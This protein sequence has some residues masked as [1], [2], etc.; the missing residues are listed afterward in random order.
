ME[1]AV[2]IE[3]PSQDVLHFPCRPSKKAFSGDCRQLDEWRNEVM[4]R[5]GADPRKGRSLTHASA[6]SYIQIARGFTRYVESRIS[7]NSDLSS[8]LAVEKGAWLE[9][10][11][12]QLAENAKGLNRRSST[13]QLFTKNRAILLGDFV[14]LMVERLLLSKSCLSVITRIPLRPSDP[15]KAVA[16]LPLLS[17][18]N[19]RID[20]LTRRSP[21][22]NSS[23]RGVSINTARF[24]KRIAKLYVDFVWNTYLSEGQRNA[25]RNPATI[26]R[27]T[28]ALCEDLPR[29]V[30]EFAAHYRSSLSSPS[31]KEVRAAASMIAKRF[32]PW[33]QSST[34][35]FR[36]PPIDLSARFLPIQSTWNLAAKR[37]GITGKR[38]YV[39]KE[40]LANYQLGVT[41]LWHTIAQE[42]FGESPQELNVERE[43]RVKNLLAEKPPVSQ[44]N[45]KRSVTDYI[46]LSPK[47]CA[48]HF[49]LKLCSST[50]SENSIEK[51]LYAAARFY[52]WLHS[53][54]WSSWNGAQFIAEARAVRQLIP[55]K[56]SSENIS[57]SIQEG[58]TFPAPGAGDLA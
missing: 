23:K 53:E 1:P 21:A 43:K 28:L 36:G 8:V 56:S 10:Y 31:E 45:P 34:G 38:D 3:R 54:G 46:R 7:V 51:Y 2:H 50:L 9:S 5:V 37:N 42:I 16:H 6:L 29:R 4:A 22:S 25:P 26:A 18:W 12:K 24:R 14:P 33:L 48:M 55:A 19:D 27:L 44:N 11:F 32:I 15:W 47:A 20:E 57:N 40:T 41:I 35:Q 39:S 58:V 13:A 52:D 49:V 30:H 17:V